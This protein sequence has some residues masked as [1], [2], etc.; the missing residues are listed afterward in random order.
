METHLDLEDGLVRMLPYQRAISLT[1][2]FIFRLSESK[3]WSEIY[4]PFNES[5]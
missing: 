5:W 2:G 4:I 3:S 1:L